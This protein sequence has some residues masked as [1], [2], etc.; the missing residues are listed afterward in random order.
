MHADELQHWATELGARAGRGDACFFL[1]DFELAAPRL[2]TLPE[3]AAAGLRFA[4]PGQAAAPVAP[5]TSPGVLRYL[6]PTPEAY[7]EAFRRVQEGLHHGD[8]FLTNLT[9]ASR[10]LDGPTLD[11]AYA[12]SDAKYRVLWPE[13]FVCFSPETFVTIDPA[14][15]IETRPMKGTAPATPEGR[16]YLLRSPKEI[17]EHAT[18]VDLMRNDLSRVARAVRVTE[19][20]YLREVDRGGSGLL[21]TSSRVGGQLPPDWAARLGQLLLELLPAGSVSG[22]PKAATLDL[23]RAAEA[24]PRGYYCGVAGYFDGRRLDSCVLIRFIEQRADGSRWF[25]SGGGVTARSREA[26]EYREL[27]DKIRLPRRK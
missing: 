12:V 26:E 23:I 19:Y 7:A 20:R 16:A 11:E 14:G 22:A 27:L 4:F 9:F 1:L 15:Y 6:P 21:Q 18:I 13:H 17:A 5:P 8:S 2:W 24:G 10:I 3:A 25:R